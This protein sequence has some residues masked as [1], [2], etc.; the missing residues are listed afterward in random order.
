MTT[1]RRHSSRPSGPVVSSVSRR[2]ISRWKQPIYITKPHTSWRHVCIV[3]SGQNAYK[4]NHD[5]YTWQQDFSFGILVFVIVFVFKNPR[6]AVENRT[7]NH[8]ERIFASFTDFR[9]VPFEALSANFRKQTTFSSDNC[10]G[11]KW[12]Y[13]LIRCGFPWKLI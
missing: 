1:V 2:V 12:L 8:I 3:R 6:A 11:Q 10:F 4:R 7:W 9:R 13:G 5:Y